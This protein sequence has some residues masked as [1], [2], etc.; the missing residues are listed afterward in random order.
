MHKVY[1]DK[2]FYSKL[3]F[4]LRNSRHLVL[5]QSPF[6]A[7]R[8]IN[9]LRP[10]LEEC[11]ARGVKI[12]VFTQQVEHRYFNQ[13]EFEQKCSDLEYAS[14]RLLS[15]GVHV[16]TLPGIHEK[17]V[18][19]DEK[20]LWEGSLNPLSHSNTSERMTRWECDRKVREAAFQHNLTKCSSCLL[21]TPQGSIHEIIG[22]FICIRRK[23]L[24]IT[25]KELSKMVRICQSDISRIEKGE[26]DCRLG[27]VTKILKA[28]DLTWCPLPWYMI[29]AMDSRLESMGMI[30]NSHQDAD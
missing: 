4:D 19:V 30:N 10:L 16:N 27:T 14:Q 1:S 29:P 17:L 2:N 15:I 9:I 22:N 13:E 28:L 21:S 12:C 24:N 6:L 20:V 26:Y 7:V 18:L 23:Q 25:Q 3:E 8:R 11:V 5:I